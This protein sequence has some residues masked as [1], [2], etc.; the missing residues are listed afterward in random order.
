[1]LASGYRHRETGALTNVGA[2]GDYWSSSPAAAGNAN[3]GFLWFTASNM[4]PLQNDNRAN[5]LTVRCVQHLQLLQKNK[6]AA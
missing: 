3:G 5:G 6:D 1:M 2:N 4:H